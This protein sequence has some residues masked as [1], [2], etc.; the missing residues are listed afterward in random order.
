MPRANI[1]VALAHG[2]VPHPVQSWALVPFAIAQATRAGTYFVPLGGSN[3]IGTIGFV[4]AAAELAAQIEAGAM[5]E[6]D[7]VVTALGSGGTAA[8][9]AVGFEK[10]GMKTRVVGVGISEPTI[11]L[12][13]LA[14]RL[15]KRTARLA[16]MTS[17]AGVR[18]ADR[19]S[20]DLRWL[21]SGYGHPT[22]AGESATRIAAEHGLILD[23]TYTAKAFR[24]RARSLRRPADGPL[25]A[26]A[27]GIEASAVR[28]DPVVRRAAS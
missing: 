24:V 25:L 6:P 23:P 12:E 21:G 22:P 5:P 15:A 16:G 10:L 14:R 19:I 18:A 20:V 11:V 13:P 17:S 4:D 26:H 27:L 3:P 8:G 28:G 9:L 2:L 7:I 1:A